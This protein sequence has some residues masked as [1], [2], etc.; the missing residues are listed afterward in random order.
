MET[1]LRPV[2]AGIGEATP[3]PGCGFEVD[4]QPGR[5]PRTGRA[6]TDIAATVVYCSEYPRGAEC[7]KQPHAELPGEVIVA[8]PSLC[9]LRCRPT[10][11]FR[12]AG[13]RRKRFDHLS[14]GRASE[15][16]DRMSLS[17]FRYDEPAPAQYRQM[18]GDLRLALLGDGH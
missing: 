18:V 13:N 2:K 17:A 8:H 12:Q 5:E 15:P 9:Q 6:Y 3:G 1:L 14:D 4:P 16:V 7:F 10:F 11:P